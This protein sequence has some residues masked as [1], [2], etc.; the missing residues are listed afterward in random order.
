MLLLKFYTLSKFFYLYFSSLNTEDSLQP[1]ERRSSQLS[2]PSFPFLT[3]TPSLGEIR[4]RYK[5][6]SRQQTTGERSPV[7]QSTQEEAYGDIINVPLYPYTSR[8][9]LNVH[10]IF[11]IGT[12]TNKFLFTHSIPL[13]ISLSVVNSVF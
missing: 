3:Q 7:R 4:A 12:T 1:T 10:H 13:L 11:Q 5:R 2:P 9:C 8:C 6:I